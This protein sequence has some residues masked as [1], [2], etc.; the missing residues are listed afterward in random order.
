MVP[1][2]PDPLKDPAMPL[3]STCRRLA[4]C[5]ATAGLLL[6]GATVLPGCEGF[7]QRVGTK[8]QS[9]LDNYAVH[10]N[11]GFEQYRAGDYRAAAE[12]FRA[13]ADRAA[14]DVASHYWWAV[15]LINL[16]EYA[17]AQLP[18]EQARAITSDT[19][20]YV[21]RILDRLA[22]VYFQL[23]RTETLYEFLDETIV[24]YGRRSRDFQ[25]Q[26]YFMTKLG[27]LDGAKL[28]F[29]KAA[30][31]ADPGDASP[32][33]ALADFQE[34]IG[35]RDKARR[36]LRYAYFINPEYDNLAQRLAG[37]GVVLGPAAGLEPPRPLTLD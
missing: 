17:D 14:S 22:E 35:Q 7:G 16:G 30:H 19:G 5:S 11:R 9:T 26:A 23:G 33:V 8:V 2:A 1:V 31:F 32:Y 18:L 29:I 34:S 20:P 24:E 4:L 3:K 27:D 15:S 36:A 25:R 10:R 12:S 37:H 28:A 13:A 6:A 21:D